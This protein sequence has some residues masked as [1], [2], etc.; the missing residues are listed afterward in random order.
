MRSAQQ[1]HWRSA[2]AGWRRN[3]RVRR[4]HPAA[5][6]LSRYAGDDLPLPERLTV[7]E[8]VRECGPC[9]RL[10]ASLVQTIGGL[11][12]LRTRGPSWRAERI[13]AALPVAAG[14]SGARQVSG[15]VRA[16]AGYCL[17]RSQLRFTVPIGLSVGVVLSLLNKGAMLLRGQIDLG[18]CVVCALDFLL[19]FAAMN[20][21]LLATTRVLGRR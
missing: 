19:P 16:A 18:M 3:L 17:Q 15:R 9:Q 7:D 20:L 1:G 2:V 12:S 4:V 21:V 8:H 5:T 13:I 10:L 6:T 14:G 11:H